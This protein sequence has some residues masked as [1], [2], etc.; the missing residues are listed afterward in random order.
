M[1]NA[2]MALAL[3]ITNIMNMLIFIYVAEKKVNE[4]ILIQDSTQPHHN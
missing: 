2:G 3:M 1:H 4:K